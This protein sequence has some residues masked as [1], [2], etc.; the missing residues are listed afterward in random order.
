MIVAIPGG[1]R[2]VSGAIAIV[3]APSGQ[4]GAMQR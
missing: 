2:S 4:S 3:W 1:L